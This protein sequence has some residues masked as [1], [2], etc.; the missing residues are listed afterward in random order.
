[1]FNDWSACMNKWIDKMGNRQQ[2]CALDATQLKQNSS[3]YQMNTNSKHRR[4]TML[5]TIGGCLLLGIPQRG[6]STLPPRPPLTLKDHVQDAK[7]IVV[8]SIERFIFRGWTS[9]ILKDEYDKE[10]V[11][12]NGLGNRALDAFVVATDII[13]NNLR[14]K[15]PR[16][17]RFQQP[18]PTENHLR[19]KGVVKIFLAN[20]WT[21]LN[22]DDQDSFIFFPLI[23]ALPIRDLPA[24]REIIAGK[25]EPAAKN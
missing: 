9:G 15:I 19:E 2:L 4:S 24:V 16:V 18:I 10:F 22:P 1:M 17:L 20:Y 12:D 8:G 23:R 7:L 3:E 5:A 11:E 14:F 21:I 25:N 13:K 6:E